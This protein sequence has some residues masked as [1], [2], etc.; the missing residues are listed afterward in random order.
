MSA[1]H[2][3]D[4]KSSKPK[5]QS[6]LKSKFK[7]FSKSMSKDNIKQKLS[8]KPSAE[9]GV[10]KE[11]SGIQGGGGSKRELIGGAPPIMPLQ[12]AL[13]NRGALLEQTPEPKS[14]PKSPLA[15]KPEMQKTTF[16]SPS[17]VKRGQA[18]PPPKEMVDVTKSSPALNLVKKIVEEEEQEAAAEGE[19]ATSGRNQKLIKCSRILGGAVLLFFL[20]SKIGFGTGR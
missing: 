12:T 16:F 11:N 6:D 10:G 19:A 18:T 13:K 20:K 15:A 2:V 17:P 1:S 3:S 14:I 7:K 8:R 4:S 9:L 5:W